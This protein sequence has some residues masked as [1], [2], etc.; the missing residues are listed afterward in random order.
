MVP[1]RLDTS[2]AATYDR[3]TLT[4]KRAGGGNSAR[5]GA[6]AWRAI[7]WNMRIS[8]ASIPM[9]DKGSKRLQLAPI[10]VQMIIGDED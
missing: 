10:V 9:G 7:T 8:R 5:G 6:K 4:I 1:V 2:L 3:E